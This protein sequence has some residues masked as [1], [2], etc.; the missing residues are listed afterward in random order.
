MWLQTDVFL[1]IV[2][3]IS[4]QNANGLLPVTKQNKF[5]ISTKQVYIL[6]AAVTE[7]IKLPEN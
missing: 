5:I 3:N 4:G 2:V 6:D 7:K 1:L